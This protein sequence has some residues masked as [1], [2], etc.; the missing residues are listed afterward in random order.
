MD[1]RGFEPVK[2][3]MWQRLGIKGTRLEVGFCPT[4]DKNFAKWLAE[5]ARNIRILGDH[6]IT[7]MLTLEGGNYDIMPLG[8]IRSFLNDKAKGNMAY[9]GDFAWEPKWDAD[10]RKSLTAL[11][12]ELGWPKGPVNA[13]ELWNEPWEGIS[14]SGWGADCL[15]YREIYTA[16]AQ[17]VEDARAKHNV[18]VLIGGG[19]SSMN[20][21]D[22]LFC[23]GKDTFLQWLDFTSIHYQPLNALSSLV[24][25]WANRKSPLGPVQVWDTET[26]IA[27]S[28]GRVAPVIASMRAQGQSR[29]A[30]VLHDVCSDLQNVDMLLAGGKTK[31]IDVVQVWAPRRAS[32]APSDSSASASSASCSSRMACPGCSPSM[33]FPT[34]GGPT[35][36]TARWS[37]SATWE[38]STRA[39]CSS[40]AACWASPMSARR[41]SFADSWPDC[42]PMPRSMTGKPSKSNSTQPKCS[43]TAA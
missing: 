35:R 18:Q 22:K 17:A 32:P 16:M 14:I 9:P 26:W 6:D 37:S 31:R 33:G 27:N 41:S 4:S 39:T 13:V 38:A 40:S 28:E 24:P 12:A 20:T 3:V 34:P 42:R 11:L 10:F 8:C 29:T 23:D 21:E 15:R 43:R 30:G 1:I 2:A 25:Q 5:T 36:T 7:C 19:C